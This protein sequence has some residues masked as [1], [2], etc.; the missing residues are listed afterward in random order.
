MDVLG[1]IFENDEIEIMRVRIGPYR[2]NKK[3]KGEWIEAKPRTI[4]V[5]IENFD[6]WS[7]DHTLALIIHPM[8]IQ[9][10]A[11]IHG[12]PFTDDADVPENL[13]STAAPTKENEWDT[14]ALHFARWDWILEEMIWAFEQSIND[15]GEEQFYT[16]EAHHL[17]QALGPNDELLGEPQELQDRTKYKNVKFYRLVNG[18]N[19]TFKVDKEG[20]NKYLERIQNG[21]VLFGKYYRG[22]W[23]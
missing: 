5:E 12:A 4:K 8:L 20:L 16:G 6:T 7:M 21:Y 11:T 23:D 22:L 3:V 15:C 18:P 13:R 10:K 14:D 17:W 2:N 19:H 9:L 1:H